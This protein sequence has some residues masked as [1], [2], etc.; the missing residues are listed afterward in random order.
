MDHL[1][2]STSSSKRLKLPKKFFD[3][4]C[5]PVDHASVPR[6]LRSA[7]KKRA[8]ESISPPMP[9]S[10]KLGHTVNKVEVEA[11]DCTKKLKLCMRQDSRGSP[12][13]AVV[14]PITK[15]EEEVVQTLYA[16]A[17]MFPDNDKANDK[18]ILKEKT[19]EK[20]FL[21]LPVPKDEDCK[22]ICPTIS[23]SKLE[24]HPEKMLPNKQLPMELDN[25]IPRVNLPMISAFSK[26]DSTIERLS[27]KSM[28]KLPAWLVNATCATQP[29]SSESAG[30]TEKD[31]TVLADRKKSW[32]TCSAH[33][34]IS[35]LI[36]VLKFAAE[37]E[38]LP[39]EIKPDE[40]SKQ[41][42]LPATNNLQMVID[43]SAEVK[44]SN[45]V[46]NAIL[47]H[48][49]LL[50]D[51]QQ[52]CTTSG[53]YSSHNQSFDVLSFSDG[54]CGV[55]A[56][57]IANRS[58][59]RLEPKTRFHNP[60]L[61]SPAQNHMIMPQTLPQNCYS[62]SY[63]DHLSAAAAQQVQIQQH[64]Y[65]GPPFS[66]PSHMAASVL[67]KQQVRAAQVA[68][69][70]YCPSEVAAAHLPNWQNRRYDYP[71]PSQTILPLS[72]QSSV[73]V[74]VGSKY[75]PSSLLEVF[76]PKY[77]QILPQQQQF[78]PITSLLAP[79]RRESHRLPLGYE[80]Y[81]GL[82]FPD[83]ASSMQLLCNDHL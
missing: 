70:R 36:R 33:V 26:D 80:E 14:G 63:A 25:S 9:Y 18:T 73:D 1:S 24:G 76:G 15:E 54:C 67:L 53:M 75:V 12:E 13:E 72:S 83:N 39:I 44:S 77:S 82:Y 30:L 74:L 47:L 27:C 52:A 46:R 60:H 19:S 22:L 62:T 31:Y 37:K 56:S 58:G 66:G 43:G 2:L 71:A 51:Q 32:K 16:L 28:A 42:V 3:E 6:K 40:R 38:E 5:H 45:E 23:T 35:R 59:N 48:K 17:G 61:H 69:P 4:D 20:K 8:R 79:K 11:P 34:Y 65:Y 64:P 41:E 50:Q 21:V 81:G 78:I 68:P 57:N 29:C 49:K 7:L 10:R 55:E